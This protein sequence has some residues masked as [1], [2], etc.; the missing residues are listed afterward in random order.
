MGILQNMH[1]A[2]DKGKERTALYFACRGGGKVV[3]LLSVIFMGPASMIF[4]PKGRE[5]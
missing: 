2:G 4:D 3:M 1:K 5:S